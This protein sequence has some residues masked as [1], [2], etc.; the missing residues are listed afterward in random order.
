MKL[1]IGDP[2][3][4][5]AKE[6]SRWRRARGWTQARMAAALGMSRE[7]VNRIETSANRPSIHS[8]AKFNLLVKRYNE[9]GQ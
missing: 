1:Q 8:R 5:Y 6:W 4:N 7:Q 9:A 2:R 3:R